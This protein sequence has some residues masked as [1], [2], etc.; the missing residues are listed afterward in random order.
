MTLTVSNNLFCIQ[1]ESP[2]TDTQLKTSRLLQ[3]FCSEAIAWAPLCGMMLGRIANPLVRSR[4]SR[5][6]S[7]VG[8]GKTFSH[9]ASWLLALGAEGT[10][11]AAAPG[12]LMGQGLQPEIWRGSVH[13]TMTMM[14]CQAISR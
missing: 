5:L 14:V 8:F 11:M 7:S 1:S 4:S 2:L 3:E 9:R 12:A 6:L 10:V 13:G